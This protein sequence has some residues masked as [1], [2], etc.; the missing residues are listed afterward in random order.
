MDKY[1]NI[2]NIELDQKVLKM[3]SR[4]LDYESFERTVMAVVYAVTEG[5]EIDDLNEQEKFCYSQ[6][7]PTASRRAK[8]WS[9][10]HPEKK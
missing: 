8:S 3:M 1:E 4:F 2:P 6:L 7:Y 9:N 5:I 10:Q